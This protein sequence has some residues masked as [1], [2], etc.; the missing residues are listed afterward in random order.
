[1]VLDKIKRAFSNQTD[2]DVEG[3]EYL[4]IDESYCKKD[5]KRVLGKA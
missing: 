4:E 3:E 5:I 1:M 2:G